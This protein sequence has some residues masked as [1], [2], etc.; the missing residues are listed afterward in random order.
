MTVL[1]LANIPSSVNSV[2]ELV[3]WGAY[4][5]R[6][7]APTQAISEAVNVLNFQ[8]DVQESVNPDGTP[9]FVARFVFTMD[10][11]SAVVGKRWNA[12]KQI[13]RSGE[14]PTYYLSN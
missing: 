14:I 11:P 9:I 7:T 8:A 6:E 12:I 5:L 1:N 10:P 2:E 4:V 3:A 13:A